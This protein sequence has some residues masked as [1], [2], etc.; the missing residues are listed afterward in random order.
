MVF[1]PLWPIHTIYSPPE[2]LQ[3]PYYTT[4]NDGILQK[5]S[6]APQHIVTVRHH[7]SPLYPGAPACTNTPAPAPVIPSAQHVRQRDCKVH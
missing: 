7:A 1:R 3:L 2:T 5:L 4:P 6:T